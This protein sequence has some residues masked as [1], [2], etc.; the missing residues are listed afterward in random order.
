MCSLETA[1][2]AVMRTLTR[3]PVE[4]IKF[5]VEG[6]LKDH[7]D[8]MSKTH[9]EGLSR[10]ELIASAINWR[11]EALMNYGYTAQE[12]YDELKKGYDH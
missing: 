9:A 2:D 11:E 3:L 6:K 1:A 10:K 12:Y 5:Q 8:L 4:E 7:M